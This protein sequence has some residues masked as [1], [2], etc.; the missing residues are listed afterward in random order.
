MDESFLVVHDFRITKL[1]WLGAGLAHPVEPHPR[2]KM[3]NL[4]CLL[5]VRQGT[6]KTICKRLG[7]LVDQV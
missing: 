4:G 3:W 7:I 2:L 1:L 6:S 5:F